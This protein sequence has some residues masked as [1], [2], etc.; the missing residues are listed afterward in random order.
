VVLKGIPI[1]VRVNFATYPWASFSQL[2]ASQ[3]ASE[4]QMRLSKSRFILG[5]AWPS[6]N[7]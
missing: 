1:W 7:R 2:H 6:I 3:A 5:K 4:S